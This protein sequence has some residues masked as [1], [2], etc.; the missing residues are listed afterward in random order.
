[1]FYSCVGVSFFVSIPPVVSTRDEIASYLYVLVLIDGSN[2]MRTELL[3][4]TCVC[5]CCVCAVF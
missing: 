5:V 3:L 1:M 4:L 2:R